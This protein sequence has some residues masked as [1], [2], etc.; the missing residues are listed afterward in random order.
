MSGRD[1]RRSRRSRRRA[2]RRSVVQADAHTS[3]RRRCT[4]LGSVGTCTRPGCR[5][6]GPVLCQPRTSPSRHGLQPQVAIDG[7]VDHAF[8]SDFQHQQPPPNPRPVGAPDAPSAAA[9]ASRPTRRSSAPRIRRQPS[10]TRS[11]GRRDSASARSDPAQRCTVPRVSPSA[12]CTR[13]NS[14]DNSLAA[15]TIS[16]QLETEGGAAMMRT[17]NITQLDV[18]AH[19]AGFEFCTA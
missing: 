1:R 18:A 6:F 16:T 5:A 17:T 14:L 12:D 9:Q 8:P 4:R 3:A 11:I 15:L 7:G 13:V 10:H 2:V 19:P